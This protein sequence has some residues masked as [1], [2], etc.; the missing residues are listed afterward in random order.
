MSEEEINVAIAEVCGWEKVYKGPEPDNR[1]LYQGHYRTFKDMPNYCGDLNAM[2]EALNSLNDRQ[3]KYF[4]DEI[5]LIIT[6]DDVKRRVS[7]KQESEA[8]LRALG[9]WRE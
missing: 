7:A 6:R 9:K 2:Q 3:F 8:F 4:Y 5:L 1:Y